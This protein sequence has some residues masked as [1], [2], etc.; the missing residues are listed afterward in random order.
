[1]RLVERVHSALP[2]LVFAQRIFVALEHEQEIAY[3]TMKRND[4]REGKRRDASAL[5]QPLKHRRFGLA[6]PNDLVLFKT[7]RNMQ[8]Q[9]EQRGIAT[10]PLK[11]VLEQQ[12]RTISCPNRTRHELNE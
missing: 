4:S 12:W 8:T 1:M 6:V 7:N 9:M 3:C 2:P 11:R 10:Q 5:V